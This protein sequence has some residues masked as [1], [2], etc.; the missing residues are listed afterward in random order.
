MNKNANT[1]DT[2]QV[3][4][5]QCDKDELSIHLSQPLLQSTNRYFRKVH[6]TPKDFPLNLIS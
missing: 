2:E 1:R 4:V 3:Y 5:T 6:R